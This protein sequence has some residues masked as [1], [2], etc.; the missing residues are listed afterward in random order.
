[1]V[2]S[3]VWNLFWSFPLVLVINKGF[4]EIAVIWVWWC[5]WNG[6][7]YNIRRSYSV[8]LSF[9]YSIVQLPRLKMVRGLKDDFSLFNTAL[10]LRPKNSSNNWVTWVHLHYS[11]VYTFRLFN[12]CDEQCWDIAG[13]K[14]IISILKCRYTCS[15]QT[16]MCLTKT[17]QLR[18]LQHVWLIVLLQT[19][20]V[21]VLDKRCFS[22]RRIFKTKTFRVYL[23]WNN[24]H[25]ILK[26]REKLEK[27]PSPRWDMNPR[28][29]VF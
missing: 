25:M 26:P 18:A 21:S 7:T 28:P 6:N 9:R 3:R 24:K 2:K 16:F 4:E 17:L 29:S 20:S 5:V 27:N 14:R 11:Q 8:L 23:R 15:S 12:I 19:K 22:K 13:V 10:K 1:M